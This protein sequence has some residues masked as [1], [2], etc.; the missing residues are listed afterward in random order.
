M[1]IGELLIAVGGVVKATETV[2]ELLDGKR[3]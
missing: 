2:I 1:G 3:N